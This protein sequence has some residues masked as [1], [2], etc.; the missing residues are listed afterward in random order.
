MKD[1]N[2]GKQCLYYLLSIY[3]KMS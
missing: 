2:C 3:Y 1:I